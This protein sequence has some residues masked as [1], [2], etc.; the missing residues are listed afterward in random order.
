MSGYTE[1]ANILHK[2]I[3]T[4][5]GFVLFG[6]LDDSGLDLQVGVVETSVHLAAVVAVRVLGF[7]EVDILNPIFNLPG[8]S[9]PE[10][11]V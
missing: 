3:D 7:Q 2:L 10:H 8:H 11:Q 5:L 9:A 1:L 6:S 4:E